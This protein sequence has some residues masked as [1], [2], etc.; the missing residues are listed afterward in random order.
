MCQ[1]FVVNEYDAHLSF[2]C[3]QLNKGRLRCTEIIWKY[4]IISDVSC[5]KQRNH[6]KLTRTALVWF[7]VI[8]L[9]Y[10]G[11]WNKTC[12]HCSPQKLFFIFLTLILR[13]QR[14]NKFLKSTTTLSP[15]FH[16]VWCLECILAM[17]QCFFNSVVAAYF[18]LA[19]SSV[20]ITCWYV[21][22]VKLEIHTWLK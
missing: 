5:Q 12:V 8:S 13:Y 14:L 11:H 20:K 16:F 4:E 18:H 6:A 17:F 21:Y 7:F 10:S 22:T 2:H 3:V 19:T 9:T 1:F 15:F